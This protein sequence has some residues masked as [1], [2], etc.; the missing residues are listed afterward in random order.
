[1][2]RIYHLFHFLPGK[3]PV[4]G[5]AKLLSV[6]YLYYRKYPGRPLSRLVGVSVDEVNI[7]VVVNCNQRVVNPGISEV[8]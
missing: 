3:S 8:V 5:N 6:L 4:V 2:R 1:L 7:P